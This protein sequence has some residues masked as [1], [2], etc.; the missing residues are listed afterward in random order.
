MTRNLYI[1]DIDVFA[2]YGVFITEGGYNGLISAPNLKEIK[3]ND[4]AEEDGIEPDLSNPVLDTKEFAVSFG[5]IKN[6]MTEGFLAFLSDGA[7]HNFDLRETGVTR[8]L[9]LVSQPNKTTI[10][11]LEAFILQFADDFPL[12]GYSYLAPINPIRQSGF[13]IDKKPFANYGVWVLDGSYDEIMRIP[14]VKKN[15]LLNY[16]NE[17]GVIYDDVWVNYQAK[18]VALRCC[19]RA[20]SISTFWRNYNALIYDLTRPNERRFYVS[21]A[22]DTFPCFYKSCSVNEF[23]IINKEIWC[24]FTLTLVFTDFR[25]K[26]KQ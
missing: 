12:N 23:T 14:S 3:Y 4:W 10:R 11:T 20:N 8:K 5:N 21:R 19:L 26:K 15:L 16:R 7:Y 1:D 6:S 9:R 17:K 13:D 18:D 24:E 2:E 25:P 22:N